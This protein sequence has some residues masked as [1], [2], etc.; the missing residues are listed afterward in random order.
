MSEH[1]KGELVVLDDKYTITTKERNKL[2]VAQTHPADPEHIANAEHL[3][4]CWNSHDDLLKACENLVRG[5]LQ[6]PTFKGYLSHAVWVAE[7]AI[8]KAEK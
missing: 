1:T 6:H 7:Q 3:V 4:K 5:Q 2:Y 8:A